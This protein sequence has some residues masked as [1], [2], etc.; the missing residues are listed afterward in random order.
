MYRTA[1]EGGNGVVEVPETISEDFAYFTINQ[2]DEARAYY[3][4][5]GYV[6]IRKL[7]SKNICQ[8]ARQS[9]DE[10]KHARIPLLR[11]HNAR[12]EPNKFNEYGH[13][14][15]PIFNVQ[16]L[17]TRPFGPFKAGVLD[18]VT[19]DP[20]IQ[21]VKRF[22]DDHPK[23]ISTMFFE[24]NA[25]GGTLAHQDSY[26][27]DSERP[28][29]ATAGWYALENIHP[30]AGRF[31]IYPGS[32]KWKPV[33]NQGSYDIAFNHKAYLKHMVESTADKKMH[34]PM[35]QQGDAIF[36]SSLTVHGSLPTKDPQH[37][38]CSITA[39]YLRHNE[40]MIQFH[41]RVKVLKFARHNGII[42]NRLHDQDEIRNRIMRTA[43]FYAPKSMAFVRDTAI[44]LLNY[45]KKNPNLR[46]TIVRAKSSTSIM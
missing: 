5:N 38:R 44:K 26:Y 39:H 46:P 8:R 35:M 11:Q 9:F 13:L 27:Q 6:V 24:G 10:T 37:S 14:V 41:R 21:V 40:D 12:Y 33:N 16:D 15:N 20:V 22:F 19:S 29:E 36:W 30:G 17:R 43:F 23:I 32:H 2:I 25:E 3:R 31:F 45:R 34:V 28:G 42:V 4:A 18:L 7:I 1:K